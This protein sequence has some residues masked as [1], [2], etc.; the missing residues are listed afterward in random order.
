MWRALSGPLN[1]IEKCWITIHEGW[2]QPAFLLNLSH[3]TPTATQLIT[4]LNRL[5]QH[6][7]RSTRS[8]ARVMARRIRKNPGTYFPVFSRLTKKPESVTSLFLEN[9]YKAFRND[10][11]RVRGKEEALLDA[12]Y[13]TLSKSNAGLLELLR[14]MSVVNNQTGENTYVRSTDQLR[15][16]DKLLE[17]STLNFELTKK[18]ASHF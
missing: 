1:G 11:V 15:L 8:M 16:S 3:M 6:R 17:A 18:F 13:Q 7:Y 12:D 2:F 10:L 9:F 14:A 5:L 4:D